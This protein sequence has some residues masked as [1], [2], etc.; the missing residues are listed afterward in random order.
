MDGS[1]VSPLPCE[2]PLAMMESEKTPPRSP[3]QHDMPPPPDEKFNPYSV[4]QQERNGQ[5]AIP[6]AIVVV[7]VVVESLPSAIAC[8]ARSSQH[9]R[10]A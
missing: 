9:Q 6:C 8:V 5:R 3:S 4:P 7:V 1:S 10:A 2:A